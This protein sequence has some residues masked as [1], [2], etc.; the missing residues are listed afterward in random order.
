MDTIRVVNSMQR[1]IGSLNIHSRSSQIG[2]LLHELLS[3]ADYGNNE[4]LDVATAMANIAYAGI[5]R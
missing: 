3:E 4:I 1:I 5:K 2:F